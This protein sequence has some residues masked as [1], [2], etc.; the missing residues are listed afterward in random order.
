MKECDGETRGCWADAAERPGFS[1]VEVLFIH[2]L[3][4]S[5]KIWLCSTYQA[6][7]VEENILGQVHGQGN[8]AF[9]LSE[10]QA[11]LLNYFLGSNKSNINQIS[12]L[13]FC[14]AL[15]DLRTSFVQKQTLHI[16]VHEQLQSGTTAL[17]IPALNLGEGI[18]LPIFQFCCGEDRFLKNSPAP[19]TGKVWYPNHP[20]LGLIGSVAY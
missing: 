14:F 13:F 12:L 7:C 20:R 9:P 11:K 16:K 19:R 17:P 8:Q 6:H 2:V 10:L 5:R 4:S 18:P 1:I 3:C 15:R